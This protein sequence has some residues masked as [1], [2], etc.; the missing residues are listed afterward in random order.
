[1]KR[2]ALVP[3]AIGLLAIAAYAQNPSDIASAIEWR[4][5]RTIDPDTSLILFYSET[6][7]HCHNQMA[8]MD[9]IRGEFP[10]VDFVAIEAHTGPQ[11]NREYF[12]AVMEAYG[13]TP[14][15][16]PRTVIG[17]RVFIGF[18]P[19]VGETVFIEQYGAW[20]G[21]QSALY[22]AT[23]ELQRAAAPVEP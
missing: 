14:R 18:A 6:C 1:M 15:G 22:E 8:W 23:M 20:M 21:Y 7:P 16:F 9:T 4:D 11:E 10:D 19:E 3:I 5:G 13:T 12:A 17:E 2:I